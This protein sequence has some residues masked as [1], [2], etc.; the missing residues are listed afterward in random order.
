VPSEAGK[1]LGLKPLSFACYFSKKSISETSSNLITTLCD[2]GAS[3]ASLHK[4]DRL[5]GT[6]EQVHNPPSKKRS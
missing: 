2:L 5:T 6:D 1:E 3:L 4:A